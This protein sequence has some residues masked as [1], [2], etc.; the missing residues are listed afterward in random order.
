MKV[1]SNFFS[2]LIWL[3]NQAYSVHD[4]RKKQA[5]PHILKAAFDLVTWYMTKIISNCFHN[6]DQLITVSNTP[7]KY[8]LVYVE[9]Y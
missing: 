6:P 1:Q 5:C 8:F 7:V 3:N 4:N 9:M 2:D